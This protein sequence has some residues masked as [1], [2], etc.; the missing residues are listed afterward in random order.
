MRTSGMRGDGANTHHDEHGHH[1]ADRGEEGDGARLGAAALR[2]AGPP[3][4]PRGD[5]TR[6]DHDGRPLVAA[7]LGGG[8]FSGGRS[9]GTDERPGRARNLS[10]STP[11]TR[12]EAA[13]DGLA[14]ARVWDDPGRRPRAVARR[15][16]PAFEPSRRL[17]PAVKKIP[18]SSKRSVWANSLT[19]K[20]G[21]YG[22][23]KP[24]PWRAARAGRIFNFEQCTASPSV[25]D[26]GSSRARYPVPT[27]AQSPLLPTFPTTP[28]RRLTPPRSP[29]PLAPRVVIVLV[30]SSTRDRRHP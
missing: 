28:S 27:R 7:P 14:S 24:S 10:V 25:E 3:A 4:G 17:A 13:S 23:E 29:R 21:C 15:G 5:P 16:V 1:G 12:R 9:R 2:G 22:L 26:D 19:E 18:T 6:G 11:K 30:T 8:H 20:R